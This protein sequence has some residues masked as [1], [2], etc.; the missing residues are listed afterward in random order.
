V[1]AV[2]PVSWI[3]PEGVPLLRQSSFGEVLN[4]N[5]SLNSVKEFGAVLKPL[6]NRI[7]PAAVPFVLN[8]ESPDT[9][10]TR[11]PIV[12][13]FL[14]PLGIVVTTAGCACALIPI[15]NRINVTCK[16]FR[17]PLSIFTLFIY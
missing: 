14:L 11:S 13:K 3:V 7:V 12:V 6:L 9:K 16:I 2:L 17:T 8:R 4:I 15:V 10:Y 1:I 5:M